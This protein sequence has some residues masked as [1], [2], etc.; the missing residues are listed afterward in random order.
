MLLKEALE[1]TNKLGLIYITLRKQPNLAIIRSFEEGLILQTIHYPDEIRNIKNMPGL[2]NNED[3]PI[4]KQELT[5]AINL[6]HHL[7][8]PFGPEEYVDE[9]KEALTDFIEEKIEQQEQNE[10]IYSNPNI[11]NITETLNASIEQ[12]KQ[13][14]G[15]KKEEINEKKPHNCGFFSTV[16]EDYTLASLNQ[17]IVPILINNSIPLLPCGLPYSQIMS[18]IF[19]QIILTLL[20]HEENAKISSVLMKHL[21]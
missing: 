7:T 21:S 17:M 4:H 20:F 14:K 8:T 19:A 11:I 15:K 2:P 18:L 10:T 6:I 1:R 12:V 16:T 5:T 3:Y 13:Q 9:Y